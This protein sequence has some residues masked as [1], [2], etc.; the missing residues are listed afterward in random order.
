[1]KN[2]LNVKKELFFL[3]KGMFLLFVLLKCMKNVLLAELL[4]KRSLAIS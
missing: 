3:K 1:M 2:A 4:L